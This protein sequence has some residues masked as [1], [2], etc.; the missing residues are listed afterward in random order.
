M[1]RAGK[2]KNGHGL[3]EAQIAPFVMAGGVGA[4]AGAAVGVYVSDSMN[5]SFGMRMAKV[6]ACT[7]IGHMIGHEMSRRSSDKMRK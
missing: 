7:G 5:M 3:R 2:R 4:V 1:F 6:A